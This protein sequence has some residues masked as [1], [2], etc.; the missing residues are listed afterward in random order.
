MW[1]TS[2]GTRT[3]AGAE[4]ALIAAGIVVM[5]DSL[6]E[7]LSDEDD[8]NEDEEDRNSPTADMQLGI[9]VFDS[10]TIPQRVAML[11]HVSRHL[12]TD[13]VPASEDTSAVDDA[14]IAAIFSEI[15]DQV[16]IEIDLH[17]DEDS[18]VEFDEPFA[19]LHDNDASHWRSLVLAAYMQLNDGSD[20]TEDNDGEEHYHAPTSIADTTLSTWEDLIDALASAILWDRDF[21]LVDGFMDEDPVSARQRK[22]LL[23]IHDNYFVE[24]PLDPT[25]SQTRVL[26]A[27]A[28]S[29]ASRRPR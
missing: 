26:L 21:E 28:R 5:L 16:T 7:R 2:S 25:T 24:P 10:L 27:Q 3:L 20:C 13:V 9:A 22:R 11:H 29:L 18:A 8:E 17:L 1:P 12:L 23:G 6:D 4:A 19:E 15:Q 14:T